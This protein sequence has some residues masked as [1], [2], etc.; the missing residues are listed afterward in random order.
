MREL[1][2]VV[3]QGCSRGEI[4]V[5]TIPRGDPGEAE[6][7]PKVRCC[8]TWST[9]LS[10]RRIPARFL[11]ASENLVRKPILGHTYKSVSTLS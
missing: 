1:I 3:A 8:H 7:N 6:P 2:C 4:S 5:P 10:G 9:L 11:I